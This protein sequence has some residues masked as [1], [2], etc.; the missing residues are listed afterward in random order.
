[1]KVKSYTEFIGESIKKDILFNSIIESLWNTE[2]IT[3]EERVLLEYELINP[4]EYINENFFDKLKSRYDKA[5]LVA[6]DISQGSKDALEKLID[7]AKQVTDFITQIKGLLSKQVKLILTQTKDKIKSNLKSNQKFIT[8]VKSKMSSD[9]SA[10]LGEIEI[11]K[12]I[13]TFYQTK[14]Y[15]ALESTIISG[16]TNFLSKEDKE[17]SIVE[18]LTI[19]NESS[20][21]IDKLVHGLNSV[22]PFSWIDKLQKVGEKGSNFIIK[23]LSFITQK[24]GG[25]YFELPITAVILGIA[26]EVNIKGLVKHGLLDAVSMFSVPFITPVIKTVGFVAT[27]IASYELIIYITKGYEDEKSD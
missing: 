18:K 10:F 16:L 3:N 24:L 23:Q 21:M 6:T 25:P 19:L 26:F 13:I 15:I 5:K 17:V 4:V 20:N 12:D 7:A 2:I 1:M 8:E 27:M 11:L 9:K 22:P 14:F